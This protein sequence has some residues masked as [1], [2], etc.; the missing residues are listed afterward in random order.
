MVL[1]S[2]VRREIG[3]GA[4][5]GATGGAMVTVLA[6]PQSAKT[7]AAT[8]TRAAR[9]TPTSYRQGATLR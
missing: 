8:S 4:A 2:L 1:R 3:E 5:A 7:S 9:L 6:F